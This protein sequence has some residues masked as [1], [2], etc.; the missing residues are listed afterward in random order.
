MTPS[1]FRA[2]RI[3]HD[4]SGHHAGIESMHADALSPGELLVKT[5]YSSVNFKDALAGTG[6]GRILRQFPLNGGID[7]AGHVVASRD[8]AFK[9]GDAVL[10]T[11]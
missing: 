7:V 1:A 11:G 3:H 8:P 9:I 4:D 10:C 5:A 6:K 2:F